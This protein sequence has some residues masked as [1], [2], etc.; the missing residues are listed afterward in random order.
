MC[1]LSW[2][3]GASTSWNPQGLS[4][5]V[6]GLLYLYLLALPPLRPITLHKFH[7][8]KFYIYFLKIQLTL[9]KFKYHNRSILLVLSII[10]FI[11][12]LLYLWQVW[13]LFM[14]ASRIRKSV[15]ML[16]YFFYFCTGLPGFIASLSPS[17]NKFRV[18]FFFLWCCGP[19]RAN[20]SSFTR[21]LD[22]TKDTS[23]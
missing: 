4:R 21:F 5:P 9:I 8:E 1:R 16:S 6:M 10:L 18:S 2:N 7:S 3:L 22:H 15:I 13:R 23:Q 17:P 11:C 14:K 12:N 19:T 20:V